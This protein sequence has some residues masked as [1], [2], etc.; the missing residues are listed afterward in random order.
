MGLYILPQLKLPWYYFLDV[1]KHFRGRALISW[2]ASNNTIWKTSLAT[3]GLLINVFLTGHT[4]PVQ[5]WVS[6][7]PPHAAAAKPLFTGSDIEQ[8]V[9]QASWGRSRFNGSSTPSR[10]K[11][12][13][14]QNSGG[15]SGMFG[16][17]GEPCAFAGSVREKTRQVH[18]TRIAGK[19]CRL[20]RKLTVVGITGQTN[21]TVR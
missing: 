21:W 6:K 11:E 5:T 20:Q 12:I 18:N 4:S 7:A 10:A 3:L 17:T 13:S 14:C 19:N 8:K 2:S 15:A 1:F 9:L 16:A